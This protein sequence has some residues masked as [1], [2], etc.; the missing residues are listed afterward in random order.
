MLQIRQLGG[1]I[2]LGH[3]DVC[4]EIANGFGSVPATSNRRDSRHSRIIPATDMPVAN[5]LPQLPLAQER[6]RQVQTV[7]LILLRREDSKLL[8]EPVIQWTVIFEFERTHGVCNMLNRV[9]LTMRVV[10]HRVDAPFTAGPVM[11]HVEY[12]VHY[13][14]A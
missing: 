13:R 10:V 4:D 3:S 14:I 1:A 5:E 2:R 6:V 11:L 7:E 12:P 9:G 8:D